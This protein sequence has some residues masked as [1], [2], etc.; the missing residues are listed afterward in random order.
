MEKESVIERY[1]NRTGF[2]N[3]IG[4]V[5]KVVD[6]LWPDILVEVEKLQRDYDA[7][8]G[9]VTCAVGLLNSENDRK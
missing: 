5:E 7:L 1:K 2:K 6:E 4:S 3:C 9:L 8:K